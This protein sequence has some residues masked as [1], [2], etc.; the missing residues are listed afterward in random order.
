MMM[1]NLAPPSLHASLRER[2]A[3]R[4][5]VSAGVAGFVGLGVWFGILQ[6]GR[7][8]DEQSH[9]R[10]TSAQSRLALVRADA[11]SIAKQRLALDT[12]VQAARAVGEHPRWA[13]LLALLDARRGDEV[14]FT[15][16]SVQERAVTTTEAAGASGRAARQQAERTAS[17]PQ[18][19]VVT[20]H[21]V[22]QSMRSVNEFAVS[23][24]SV[25]VLSG[26]RTT[27]TGQDGRFGG[28][29]PLVSFTMECEIAPVAS[30]PQAAVQTPRQTE[31]AR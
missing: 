21:G 7:V 8:S 13:T 10:M 16:L 22:A 1:V 11:S 20:I 26:V 17:V 29:S 6:A 14:V 2:S 30:Q 12:R 4:L 28:A 19:Y 18:K 15:G 27:A 9:Q 31:A 25:P 3:A 23:L 24:E 5:W